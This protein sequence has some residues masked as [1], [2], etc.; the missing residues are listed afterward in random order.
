VRDPGH[1][2]GCRC[3]HAHTHS[4]T[5]THTH[6]IHAYIHTLT[7]THIHTT[8]THTYARTHITWVH[9]GRKATMAGTKTWE[10]GQLK[11]E[12]HDLAIDHGMA[13]AMTRIGI[14]G[15]WVV[16]LMNGRQV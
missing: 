11:L 13:T 1:V 7:H 14:L 10:H 6:N 9:A 12:R 8:Y 4:H 16:K 15:G 2:H 3:T 5:H